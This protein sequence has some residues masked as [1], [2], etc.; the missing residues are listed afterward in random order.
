MALRKLSD[1]VREL[2]EYLDQ[3]VELQDNARSAVDALRDLE[4]P[5]KVPAFPAFGEV[6][7]RPRGRPRKVV[8]AELED[9]IGEE[10]AKLSGRAAHRVS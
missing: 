2:E 1:L 3:L 5:E 9:E 6:P 8:Q 7:K 10:S 4:A